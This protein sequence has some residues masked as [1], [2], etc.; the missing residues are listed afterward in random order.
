MQLQRLILDDAAVADPG[1]DI[2]DRFAFA[3]TVVERVPDEQLVL[4]RFVD[5][6][7]RRGDHLIGREETVLVHSHRPAVVVSHPEAAEEHGARLVLLDREEDL[8]RRV[9]EVHPVEGCARIDGKPCTCHAHVD[10]RARK[11]RRQHRCRNHASF[12]DE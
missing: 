12:H 10:G 5:H 11:G 4:G 2:V 8:V 6:R 1:Q 7:S 3:Q 9:V